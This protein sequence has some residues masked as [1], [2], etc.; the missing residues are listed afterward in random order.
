ME[1]VLRRYLQ[2]LESGRYEN[3]LEL[4]SADAVVK[5]PLYGTVKAADFYRNLLN[6]TD[7]ST[8]TLLNLFVSS[9]E[10]NVAAAQFRYQWV[11]RNNMPVDFECVDVF[12]FTDRGEIQQLT[13]IYDTCQARPL[14]ERV[15]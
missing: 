6:I 12:E 1:E 4:F 13:I 9:T 7:R 3:L 8:I 14:F 11:L 15:Y 10:S 5:S 2:A